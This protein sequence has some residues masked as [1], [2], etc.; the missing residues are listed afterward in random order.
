MPLPFHETFGEER[1]ALGEPVECRGADLKTAKQP[2]AACPTEL[3]LGA[4]DCLGGAPDR[5]RV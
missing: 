3:E 2:V 4:A 5:C 1:V